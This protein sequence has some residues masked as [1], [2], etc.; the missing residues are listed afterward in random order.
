ME[1]HWKASSFCFIAFSALVGRG[2]GQNGFKICF[3]ELNNQANQ[4]YSRDLDT[5]TEAS[6]WQGFD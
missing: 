2:G 4:L 3:K 6:D 1:S 5:D